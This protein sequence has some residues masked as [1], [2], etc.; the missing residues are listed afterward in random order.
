MN[1]SL[2]LWK[3]LAGLAIFL[4]GM[5]LLE[6]SIKA[7]SGRAFRKMIRQYTNGRL[8]SMSSGALVTAILQSSSAVSL[9]VLAFVGAGV[10]TME[11][12]IGVMVGSNIGTTFTAWVVAV[13][14]F[15]LKIESFALP[16]IAV[17]GMILIVFGSPSRFF[18]A[19]RLLMGFGFLF[20]GLDFMKTSVESFTQHFDVQGI[21]A[22]GLWLYALFG[23]LITAL[24]QSSSASIAIVLTAVNSGLI[25]F[26][27][28]AAMVIGANIGT[29]ITVLLGSIAAIP[30]KKRVSVSHLIFN[31]VTGAAAFIALHPLVWM[32]SCFFDIATNS[33][34]ALALFHTLF[35]LL[36]ALLFF[37]F[38]GQL[39][40]FLLRTYPDHK[41]RLTVFLGNTPTE[42]PDAAT[43][44]LRQEIIHLFKECQLYNLRSFRIDDKLVFDQPLPF[45]KSSGKRFQLHDQYDSVKLL[46]GEIIEFYA[47]L[48]NEKLVETEAR[49]LERIIFAS[50]NIMNSIKNIKGMRHNLEEFEAADNDF[51]NNQYKSFRRRL[52]ELYH[53]INR[54]LE[55]DTLQEQYRELLRSIVHLEQIDKRFIKD[56]MKKAASGAIKEIDIAS[57]LMVNRLFNQACRLQIFALKDLLLSQEQ[58]RDF[59]HALE[60]KAFLDEE[61][62]KDGQN[63]PQ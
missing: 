7:M 24:M 35:N 9:M 3:L 26:T 27:M 37:P 15:K 60:M 6:D 8:R 32:V 42:V 39:S 2:D 29:T 51:L 1:S 17:G 41:E 20:L 22:Y 33:V 62:A 34:M 18:Q 58:I 31:L 13:F 56:T 45:E 40:R 14:G 53:D 44:S 5:F 25:G 55:L 30:S 49:E 61:K 54:F 4:Y 57:L 19:S 38:I 47:K 59:D 28:A 43:A 12:G 46:H 23:I 11:N 16:L 48:L 21:A 63:G 52:M 36:G 50:R 10:M